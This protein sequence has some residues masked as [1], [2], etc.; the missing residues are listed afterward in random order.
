MAALQ[1]LRHPTSQDSSKETTV[2]PP[3]PVIAERAQLNS[4]DCFNEEEFFAGAC[5]KNCS[6]LTNGQYPIRSSPNTCC[7]AEPC[8]FPSHISFMGPFVC[9]GYAVDSRGS[10]PRRPGKCNSDEEMYQ[11]VCFKP[12]AVLTQQEFPHRTG[13]MTCCKYEPPC[14]SFAN[15]RSEVVKQRMQLGVYRNA[16]RGIGPCSGYDVGGEGASGPAAVTTLG[17]K[18]TIAHMNRQF[19]DNSKIGSLFCVGTE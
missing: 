1:E 13:P 6:A 11:G 19:E 14:F 9:T 17:A 15:L 5:Y 2:S 10:C 16:G 12:C 8:I 3:V 7:S 4:N 18:G